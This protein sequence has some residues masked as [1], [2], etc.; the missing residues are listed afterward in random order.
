VNATAPRTEFAGVSVRG[1]WKTARAIVRSAIFVIRSM[2]MLPSKP[3]EWMTERPMIEKL[4]FLTPAGRSEG[5][6]Y[7]P[8]SRGPHPGVLVS[9]GVVPLGVELPQVARMGDALARAGFAALLYWSPTMRDLRVD[10]DD[11]ATLASAYQTLIEQ[12]YVDP[13][14]SGFIGTCVGGSFALM[15]AASTSIR[16]KVAFVSAYA[17]FSSMWTLAVDIARAT[18]TLGDVRESWDVDPLTWK[19]YVRSVTD[20]LE[21]GEKRR[22]RDTF[23]VQIRWNASKTEILRSPIAAHL[24]PGELS[25]DGQAVFGL[26]TAGAE[27]VESALRQLPPTAKVLL[28]KMSPMTYVDDLTAPLIVLLHDRDDQVIPVGESRRLWSA[29]SGRPGASYTEMQFKHLN[30]TKLSPLRLARELVRFYRA[31]YPLF[32]ETTA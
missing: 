15:A 7:R 12:P 14:R 29:L 20:W 27:D 16:G 19:T 17:P 31:L 18:C 11:I 24:D 25:Q 23:E 10:P 30:P 21:P 32:R 26:L 8:P 2:P 13:N 9:L 22:L 4:S 28:T 5:D 6:L 3:I 1:V